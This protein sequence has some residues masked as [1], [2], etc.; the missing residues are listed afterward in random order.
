VFALICFLCMCISAAGLIWLHIEQ[1][2][3]R[4]GPRLNLFVL[5]MRGGNSERIERHR[6]P[7]KGFLDESDDCV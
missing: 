3:D 7:G 1:R 2:R 5:D 4:R 6:I